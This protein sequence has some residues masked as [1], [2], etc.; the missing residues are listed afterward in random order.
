MI[1]SADIALITGSLTS[2]VNAISISKPKLRNIKQNLF[3]AFFV[4]PWVFQLRQEFS[5][6]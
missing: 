3:D 5:I 1:E 2:V 4:I 6:R